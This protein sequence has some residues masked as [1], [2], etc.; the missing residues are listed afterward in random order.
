MVLDAVQQNTSQNFYVEESNRNQY[1]DRS[2]SFLDHF[3]DATEKVT[4][5]D[6]IRWEHLD[7]EEQECEY[8]AMAENGVIS[9]KGVIFVCDC[10]RNELQLGDCSD[11]SNCLTISLSKGGSLVVNRDN[12]DE[13]KDAITMF[14]PEDRLL[15][16]KAIILN[17]R[18][19]EVLEEIK[20]QS[21]TIGGKSYTIKE[22]DKIMDR[23]DRTEEAIKE[24]LQEKVEKQK[25]EEEKKDALERTSERELS[26]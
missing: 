4:S 8:F 6:R 26:I 21:F 1:N 24:Q 10:G 15:I 5:V 7:E 12:I 11:R 16:M 23:F 19:N 14:S 25:E 2:V 17:K 20:D 13:L 18:A 9:Y 22:W 3:K